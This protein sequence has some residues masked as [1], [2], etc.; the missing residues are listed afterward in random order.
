[1]VGLFDSNKP[2]STILDLFDIEGH[3][4]LSHRL[5]H[6][7]DPE[8]LDAS[9]NLYSFDSADLAVVRTRMTIH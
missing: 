6:F 2:S 8:C 4:L 1:V 5:D 3:L 7:F 9:G